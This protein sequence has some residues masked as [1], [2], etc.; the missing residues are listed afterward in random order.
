MQPHLQLVPLQR[1]QLSRGFMALVV[2]LGAASFSARARG[3]DCACNAER[4]ATVSIDAENRT[5]LGCPASLEGQALPDSDGDGIPD[6]C[7]ACACTANPPDPET[8]VIPACP[9]PPS[10]PSGGAALISCVDGQITGIPVHSDLWFVRPITWAFTRFEKGSSE[11]V[12]GAHLIW[13]RNLDSDR[14]ELVQLGPLPTVKQTSP[15][16]WYSRAGLF[17]QVGSSLSQFAL[18]AALGLQ[19]GVDY[20]PPDSW[21]SLG[22]QL[23]LATLVPSADPLPLLVGVGPHIG[24]LD[25]FS[26]APFVQFDAFHDLAPSYGV[27]IEFDWGVLE[28]LGLTRGKL[29]N[30][31]A[32]AVPH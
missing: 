11:A 22:P 19:L 23:H 9:V 24:V 17:V 1:A 8:G 6:A 25:V 14:C 29:L 26:L 27:W 28:D 10:P 31:A 18:D 15:P 2:G 7:D 12:G 16:H 21:W 4:C 3:A 30:L 20:A 32:A 13:M 5:D